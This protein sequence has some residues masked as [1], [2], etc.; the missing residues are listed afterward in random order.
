MNNYV[1]YHSHLLTPSYFI[2]LCIKKA[3]CM[4]HIILGSLFTNI[5]LFLDA[6]SMRF[7]NVQYNNQR[8][9]IS[10]SASGSSITYS[11]KKE[12]DTNFKSKYRETMDTEPQIGEVKSEENTSV[13]GNGKPTATRKLSVII[14]QVIFRHNPIRLLAYLLLI[15]LFLFSLQSILLLD[16]ST[17]HR[18]LS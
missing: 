5:C 10:K 1:L 17:T 11:R 16:S 13:N 15:I 3:S 6:N 2:I 12:Q 4:H 7:E 8:S 18:H 9:N 14:P